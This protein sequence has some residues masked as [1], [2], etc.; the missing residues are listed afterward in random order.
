[1]KP[2]HTLR[3]FLISS[4]VFASSPLLHANPYYWDSDGATSGFGNTT[5]T[6]GTSAFWSTS[7]T[8]EAATANPPSPLRTR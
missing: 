7:A 6:W 3:S 4:I 2:T 1:M 8:G 5:G